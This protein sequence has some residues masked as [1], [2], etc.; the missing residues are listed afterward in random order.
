MVLRRAHPDPGA[1]QDY[2]DKYEAKGA[3][4]WAWTRTR[5]FEEGEPFPCEHKKDQ[6]VVRRLLQSDPVYAA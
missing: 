2:V 1:S 6:R 5:R 3:R 4:R